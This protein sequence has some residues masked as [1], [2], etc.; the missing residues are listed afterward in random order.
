MTPL[1]LLLSKLPD[2]KKSGSGWSARCPA[3]DDSHAS[4]SVSAG[5]DGRVLLRCHAG[6]ETSEIV[7]ALGLRLANLFPAKPDAPRFNQT[8]PAFP[9][10]ND[11]VDALE[12]RLGPRSASWTYHDLAGIP[13]G[14]VVR[15]DETVGKEIRPVARFTD[16]WRIKAMPEPRPLYGLTYLVSADLVIVV[17]G[18]KCADAA[19]KLGFVA[20][21]SAGG[22]QS[23]SKTNWQPLAGK[24]V[25]ILPDNDEP[26]RR[27]A[28]TVAD[29][30]IKLKPAPV[31]R[32][33]DL[34]ALPDRGD[35]VDW[36]E[37]HG[38]AAEPD[39]M[40]AEIEALAQAGQ[41]LRPTAF[42]PEPRIRCEPDL[43]CLADVEPQA[44][45]WLWPGRIP[46]GRLTLLVGRPGAGKS[47]LTVDLAARVSR[48]THWPDPG[49]DRAPLGDTLLIC[50]EDDPA[51]TIRPR[52]DA[53]GADC[54]RV[55]LLKAAKLIEA[56]GNERSVAFDLSNV[57]LIR[58]SLARLPGCKLVIVDPI[59]SYLG[60]RVD[61]HRDNEVRAV[62][63]PLAALAAERGVAV[64]LVCHTRKATASFADDTALGSRAFVGLARS[65][66]HLTSD[67][68]DRDRKLFLPG[69][70]NLSASPPGL[71]FRIVGEPAKVEWEP[72]PLEGFHA[73][74]AMIP[75]DKE[76][77]RGPAPK[78]RDAA[79][80]WLA[81]LLKDGPMAVDE[82]KIQAKDAGLAWRTVRRANEVLGIVACKRTFAGGWEWTLPEGVHL[83]AEGG[84]DPRR[85][86]SDAK[87]GHLRQ[88][89]GENVRNSLDFIEGDQV[90]DNLATFGAEAETLTTFGGAT[91]SR[92]GCDNPDD[93]DGDKKSK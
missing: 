70:S 18:E 73:D 84:R 55:H 4:L 58:D 11:A 2:V 93:P 6:C 21:T 76:V 15:W 60:G 36:I 50:A 3:H 41:P 75:G 74:D 23:L 5:D 71:A 1:E 66:L 7:A 81:D 13:V 27:Y 17:E 53:N 59:G 56:D 69:K 72:E 78:T 86:P 30:L 45:P 80:D 65:V 44:V 29:I 85:C 28:K 14:L 64:V 90:T 87:P 31:V 8:G 37:A 47:F 82:I 57:E 51:D 33:I 88:N 34:P 10:A 79:S 22:S 68:N 9:S 38:D 62:L 89:A 32:I 16:G 52:L 39:G 61:S 92:F 12:R 48:A 35:I 91:A 49:F 42:G 46:L 26:G 54:R 67:E 20:T 19:R 63:A 77:P 25:W 83:D 40:R 24:E 43:V